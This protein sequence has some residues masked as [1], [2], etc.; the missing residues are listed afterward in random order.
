MATY[1]L[2]PPACAKQPLAHALARP[3][4]MFATQPV[5][6]AARAA[7]ALRSE[8]YGIWRYLPE[9]KSSKIILSQTAINRPRRWR[10]TAQQGWS[11]GKEESS[12]HCDNI[13]YQSVLKCNSY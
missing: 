4:T 5:C 10:W 6:N 12:N 9:R 7:H 3:K 2:P 1:R 13:T 8:Q 11:M